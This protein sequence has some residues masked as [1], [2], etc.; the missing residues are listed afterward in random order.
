MKVRRLAPG[1]FVAFLAVACGS[2]DTDQSARVPRDKILGEWICDYGHAIHQ[3]IFRADGTCLQ[4]SY[5]L[6]DKV[7]RSEYRARQETLYSR[8]S[9]KLLSIEDEYTW[10]W[11]LT[12]ST[13]VFQ[14]R[15]PVGEIRYRID[16]ITQNELHCTAPVGPTP[17]R[18]CRREHYDRQ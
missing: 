4:R 3:M 10:D 16:K 12:G 11:A 8:K 14:D 13:I 1:V 15:G 17:L 2:S 6:P 9:E 18:Y 7:T 5:A